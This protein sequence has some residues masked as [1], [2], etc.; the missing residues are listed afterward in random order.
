MVVHTFNPKYLGGGDRRRVVRGQPGQ[1]FYKTLFGQSKTKRTGD[2]IQVG[3]PEFNSQLYREK[4]IVLCSWQT[5]K[6][7]S[8]NEVSMV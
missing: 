5:F 3:G 2:V 6:N 8:N 1:N 4:N 7:E